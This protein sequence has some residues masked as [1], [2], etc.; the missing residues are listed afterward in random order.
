MR[1]L[2]ISIVVFSL[3]VAQAETTFDRVTDPGNPVVSSPIVNSYTGAFWIDY[4]QDGWLDLAAA[5]DNGVL[6][7]RN[8]S[9]NGFVI[10]PGNALGLDTVFYRGLTW[11]DYDNDGDPDLFLAGE[12]G[13]L[14]RNDG[15]DVF[16]PIVSGDFGTIEAGGW[17][18]T[19]FDYDNDGDLDL[20]VGLPAGFMA[21]AGSRPSRFYVNSGAPDYQLTRLDTGIVSSFGAPFTSVTASDWDD[22]GDMDLSVGSG[23]A[24]GTLRPDYLFINQLTESGGPG[25]E[26]LF[27]P[28][29]AS[30]NAD[31]QVFNWID[32]DNDGDLDCQRTNWANGLSSVAQANDFYRNDNGTY[33][34]ITTGDIATDN[35]V[36]LSGLWADLDNDGDLD[37]IICNQQGPN[38]YYDNNGDGTFTKITT[39]TLVTEFLN[40]TGASAGDFDN[41]GDLDL[42]LTG[43][44]GSHRLFENKADTNG[45]SWLKLKLQGAVSNVS[46]IGAKVFL[47]A[48]IGGDTV[49]QRREIQTQNTFLGANSL[50]VHFGL[51]GAAT[52]DSLRI[53]WP[54]GLHWDTTDVAVNQLLFVEENCMDLDGDSICAQFDNCPLTANADQ[55]DSDADGVGDACCCIGTV[56]NVDGSSGDDLNLADL[57][58]LISHLFI[59]FEPLGCPDEANVDVSSDGVIALPDLSTLIDH[60]FI[61]FTPLPDCP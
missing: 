34:K 17:T 54:S 40:H 35:G 49:Q 55:T 1:A 26:R 51:G 4:N 44:N 60:L 37:N 15:N 52:V 14:Y 41:D 19:W 8:D 31:G 56:G 9:S 29:I 43:I 3:G 48:T 38:R 25:F 36:S 57:S 27:G 22:D 59:G 45:N 47:W 12:Q 16:T 11:G 13:W 58:F 10:P 30:E 42:Y 21:Y 23:P 28:P 24:N 50:L 7:F 6:I 20:Y 33:V 61:S 5:G 53:L 2:P 46:A 39:G 32:F 18:P